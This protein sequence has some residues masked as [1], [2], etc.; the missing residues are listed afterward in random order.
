MRSPASALVVREVMSM[1]RRRGVLI[2]IGDEYDALPELDWG[3]REALA[4]PAPVRLVRAYHHAQFTRPWSPDPDRTRDLPAEAMH[5][6]QRATAYLTREWPDLVVESQ[7]VEGPASDVLVRAS[8]AAGLT[9]L[10]S[11]PLS[12]VPGLVLGSVSST[13]AAHAHGPVVVVRGSGRIPAQRP[14]V[15]V[16]V[17]GSSST[18][19][20]LRFGF[21]HAERHCRSLHAVVCTNE[22]FEQRVSGEPVTAAACEAAGR[23]LSQVLDPWRDEFPRVEL[24]VSVLVAHPV[25]GLVE[26]S[27]GHELLVV[28]SGLSGP[29]RLAALL[30]SVTQG[31]LHHAE[32]PVAIV[33]AFSPAIA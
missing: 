24:R 19:D 32:S 5:V 26:A 12:G 16:G 17:D 11:R 4:R 6:L 14:M 10:G 2:G 23:W 15:V 9:V 22:S 29:P 8:A 7:A 18:A 30:G 33:R 27:A 13:V 1:P 3:A 20:V 21:E 28:G 25:A 31:V